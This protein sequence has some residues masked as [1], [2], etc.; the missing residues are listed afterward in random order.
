MLIIG[1]SMVVAS[2]DE[3]ND[4]KSSVNPFHFEN[5][6]NLFINYINTKAMDM[7]KDCKLG[8]R[9]MPSLFMCLKE[10]F[11]ENKNVKSKDPKKAFIGMLQVMNTSA[12]CFSNVTETQRLCLLENKKEMEKTVNDNSIYFGEIIDMKL[13]LCN[14]TPEMVKCVNDKK[15]KLQTLI[16][17]MMN[18]PEVA[19]TIWNLGDSLKTCLTSNPD[20]EKCALH[21][22]MSG[23]TWKSY[24]HESH[25]RMFKFVKEESMKLLADCKLTPQTT[26]D[27]F[28]CLSKKYNENNITSSLSPK[29]KFMSMMRFVNTSAVCYDN[30]TDDQK[31]C[32][33]QKK[34]EIQ[35]NISQNMKIYN[36]VMNQVLTSCGVSDSNTPEIVQCIT[37]IHREMKKMIP[38]LLSN[39]DIAEP[40][41]T[42]ME[43]MKRCFDNKPEIVKCI[44]ER[45]KYFLTMPRAKTNVVSKSEVIR[46]LKM[47]LPNCNITI[48]TNKALY[49][50][51]K[52]LEKLLTDVINSTN[53]D[54]QRKIKE[55]N[56]FHLSGYKCLTDTNEE[57]MKCF[58][59]QGTP[60][61][62]DIIRVFQQKP[63]KFDPKA[64]MA[65]MH[66]ML[67]G[68]GITREKTPILMICLDEI[69][70]VVMKLKPWIPMNNETRQKLIEED[71]KYWKCFQENHSEEK[72]CMVKIIEGFKKLGKKK[73]AA[74][75]KAASI[76]SNKSIQNMINSTVSKVMNCSK[77]QCFHKKIEKG[78]DIFKAYLKEVEMNVNEEASNEA[79]E[80]LRKN[81]TLEAITSMFCFQNDDFE[82][83]LNAFPC[84]NNVL[85]E[86]MEVVKNIKNTMGI[87]NDNKEKSTSQRK[88]REAGDEEATP[89]LSI[90]TFLTS[91]TNTD[92]SKSSVTV[93]QLIFNDQ[94]MERV[95]LLIKLMKKFILTCTS[96]T[97][98]PEDMRSRTNKIDRPHARKIIDHS[99]L[100]RRII[101]HGGLP[102]RPSSGFSMNSRLIPVPMVED[103]SEK[104][105]KMYHDINFFIDNGKLEQVTETEEK[106]HH[107]HNSS[108]VITAACVG[109]VIAVI[110]VLLSVFVAIMARRRCSKRC[111][112]LNTPHPSAPIKACPSVCSA[113][114]SDMPPS[115]NEYLE[116]GKYQPSSS[117]LSQIL[118]TSTKE[119]T[120]KSC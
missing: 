1:F 61:K 81:M 19:E 38:E 83:I 88:K 7:F 115:Y 68:C 110:S 80:I 85:N 90:F 18:N 98:S 97:P 109:G 52:P 76:L 73:D 25:H 75:R 49:E 54:M 114:P 93:F 108:A 84:F 8:Y 3:R 72:S 28:L 102:A 119:G 22:D 17:T 78:V 92:N 14:A 100:R 11:D 89:S 23:K 107:K 99:G 47:M 116:A 53:M 118:A 5:I 44:K 117:G 51:L 24:Y 106:H 103:K 77:N 71:K 67:S 60:L 70:D 64:V 9:N 74:R 62:D 15:N 13:Q 87:G 86:T 95:E 65:R 26:P 4:Y 105:R 32:L 82:N 57:T 113:F 56:K 20:T 36:N 58:A 21:K 69:T 40:T 112:T 27:V 2:F 37:P 46:K 6:T 41:W 39:L 63:S 96:W 33:S 48:T 16:K 50:C 55:L 79:T 101:D 111:N 59:K 34:M 120:E 91:Y 12:Q 35:K 104:C 94:S 66:A 43:D 10:K 42:L 45:S 30:V 29:E 31:L